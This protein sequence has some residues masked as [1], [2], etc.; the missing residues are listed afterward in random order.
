MDKS[1]KFLSLLSKIE[2]GINIY[3]KY[4]DSKIIRAF[5]V[6]EKSFLKALA[7]L[8]KN[9]VGIDFKKKLKSFGE[10]IFTFI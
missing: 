5:L 9:V 4:L 10:I 8:I 3:L 6:R 2:S 7:I 1:E